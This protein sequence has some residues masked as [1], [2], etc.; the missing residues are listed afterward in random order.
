MHDTTVR[1][2]E[3]LPLKHTEEYIKAKEERERLKE[4][5]KRLREQE[6]GR[7]EAAKRLKV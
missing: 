1:G 5:R 6:R 4:E 2:K 7:T 3:G